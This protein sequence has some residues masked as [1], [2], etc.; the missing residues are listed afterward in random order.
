MRKAAALL[1][2]LSS[3]ALATPS[4]AAADG[5]LLVKVLGTAVLPDGKITKVK[6]DLVGLPA[7]TQTEA[8][9]NVVPTL[10]IE[11]F[12]TP[13]VSVETICCLTQHDVDGTTG[14]PGAE[15]VADAKLIPATFTLKYHPVTVGPIQPYFGAGPAYFLFISDKPGAAARGLGANGF[16][17][18]DAFGVALQAGVDVPINDIGMLVSLDAKKYFLSTDAHWYVG[19]T[20]VIRT[21][22]KLDP[23]VLSAGVGFRF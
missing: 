5:K 4:M 12:F 19:G 18:D 10:A 22:H 6:R 20:E 14:L 2:L 13:N 15:L 21:E 16:K 9:D 11:Y 8:N 17:L 1:A 3:V 7:G 23:W